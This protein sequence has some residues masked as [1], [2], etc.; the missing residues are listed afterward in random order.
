VTIGKGKR[1]RDTN[2][3]AKF[4]VDATTG[5]C[6]HELRG[7]PEP[8]HADAHAPIHAAHE[9]PQQENRQPPSRGC[10]ALHVLQFLQSASDVARCSSDGSAIDRPCMVNSGTYF[11]FGKELKAQVHA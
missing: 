4:I 5:P 6:E 11:A 10:A 7:A 3:L 2:Q 1:P 8:N 9:R